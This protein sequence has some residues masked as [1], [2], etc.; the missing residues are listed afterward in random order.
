MV[1][2]KHT[3]LLLEESFWGEIYNFE[4]MSWVGSL[5]TH[6]TTVWENRSAFAQCNKESF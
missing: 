3:K 6:L 2:I 1:G 4:E 5:L